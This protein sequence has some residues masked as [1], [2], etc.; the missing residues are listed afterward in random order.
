MAIHVVIPARYA[1]TRFPG[2]PLIDIVGKPMIQHVYER[3]IEAGL[4]SVIV[5][6]DDDRIVT[7]VKEFGGQYCLTKSTHQSGTERI[8]EVIEKLNFNDDD[9]VI[10]LQGDEPL[11]SPAII[12]QVAK[13]L[14]FHPEVSVSTLCDPIDTLEEIF[15]PGITK[16]LMDKKGYAINFTRAPLP[17]FRDGFSKNPKKLPD[18]F[19]FYRHLGIYAQRA[20]FIKKYIHW[21]PSPIEKIESLEQL[22]VLWYGEKIHVT[23]AC[24]KP[25]PG[26]DTP[27]DLARLLSK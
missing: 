14:E 16:V 20:T 17:W 9:I 18:S 23:I 24:E 1:S 11:I 2:K 4:D 15:D 3:A 22:R 19:T 8:E 13:D 6:T 26:I 12:R 7:A 27:E 21:Q 25:G 5:A 10:N